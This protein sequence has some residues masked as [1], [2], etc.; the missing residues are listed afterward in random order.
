MLTTL[1]K[2]KKY[3]ILLLFPFC[4]TGC[5]TDPSTKIINDAIEAHGGKRFENALTEFDFRG[6]HY[7]S[8]RKGGMFTYTREFSDSSGQ[9]KDV[10]SNDGFRR[11]INGGL[12]KISGERAAAYSNSV[13]SVL[14]FALLPYGLNDPAVIKTYLGE[15]ELR[16]KKYHL[17]RVTFKQDGGGKDHEDVFLYWI[18]QQ[19]NIVDY[20][21]Y[22]YLTDG[23]GLRFREAINQRTINGILFHDYNNYKPGSD[24]VTLDEMGTLFEQNQLDL[25]SVI[26]HEN[27]KVRLLD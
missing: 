13:N 23:G 19:T 17:I 5:F 4:L 8:H 25:L 12:A 24:T 26:N 16:G 20:L 10:L 3:L 14:Y 21:A 9:I 1:H 6:R 2:M 15:T 22:S 27:I 18:N 7:T 11:E